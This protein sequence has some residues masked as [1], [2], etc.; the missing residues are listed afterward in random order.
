MCQKSHLTKALI[1]RK[2][3]RHIMHHLKCGKTNRIAL[4]V[5]SGR[6]GASSTKCCLWNRHLTARIWTS[7]SS[8]FAG[9]STPG[10]QITTQMTFG[11]W[12][13]WCFEQNQKNALHAKS[14]LTAP[15]LSITPT[16]LWIWRAWIKPLS[17]R[18][19]SNRLHA[20]NLIR[21]QA[22]CSKR[23]HILRR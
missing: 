18:L 10:F 8:V 13:S 3:E 21:L 9:E 11:R 23:S 2:Q 6:W 15:S 5:M 4:R 17:R 19:I 12:Y 22:N 14:L 16:S 1:T 20:M 7:S